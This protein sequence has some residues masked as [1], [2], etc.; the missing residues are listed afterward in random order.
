MSI[1]THHVSDTWRE[2]QNATLRQCSLHHHG[3]VVLRVPDRLQPAG[4]PKPVEE[5]RDGLEEVRA[6]GVVRDG[7]D[8]GVGRAD[9][10]EDCERLAVAAHLRTHTRSAAA[11]VARGAE[12]GTHPAE[13]DGALGREHGRREARE[14]PRGVVPARAL[15][16][17][18]RARAR[19]HVEVLSNTK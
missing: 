2:I 11:P 1:L 12:G 5:A 8:G 18:Q 17:E 16:E 7:G 4:D 13:D 6:D 9:P 19:A 15:Q 10:V 3:H 14:Q